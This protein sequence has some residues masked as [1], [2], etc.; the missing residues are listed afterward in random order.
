MAYYKFAMSINS[1]EAIE[2]YNRGNMLRD[3]TF[4]KD[5]IHG[6]MMVIKKPPKPQNIPNTDSEAPFKLF[7]IGNNKPIKL[8]ILIDAIEQ[9]LGKKAQKKY[10]G[11]QIG[12]VP[13]TFAD[14]DDLEFEMGFRPATS[15]QDGI[16][17]FIDWFRS[18]HHIKK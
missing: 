9:G 15:I 4:I 1:G 6:I 3:F 11:M 17:E 2:L 8:K 12:D 18:Y 14:I 7:N 13:A 16:E 10:I 5:I